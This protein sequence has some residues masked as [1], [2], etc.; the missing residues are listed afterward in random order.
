[1]F[2]GWKEQ[3]HDGHKRNLLTASLI[4]SISFLILFVVAAVVA[5]VVVVAFTGSIFAFFM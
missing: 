3:F 2:N 5:V 4:F 1:M